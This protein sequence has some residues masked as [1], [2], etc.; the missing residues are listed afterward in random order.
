M[1]NLDEIFRIGKFIETKM[2]GFLEVR[3][4]ERLE[5]MGSDAKGYGISLGDGEY[6]LKLITMVAY[7]PEYFLKTTEWYTLNR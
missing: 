7:N 6:V 1:I 2:N 3:M 5:E 4:Q